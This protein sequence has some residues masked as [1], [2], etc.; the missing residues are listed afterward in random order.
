LDTLQKAPLFDTTFCRLL[1]SCWGKPG[2]TN[3]ISYLREFGPGLGLEAKRS[4]DEEKTYRLSK[5][6]DFLGKKKEIFSDISFM[7]LDSKKFT[8]LREEIG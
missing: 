2:Q 4:R 5:S 1:L 6:Q 7:K 3:Q 8:Y